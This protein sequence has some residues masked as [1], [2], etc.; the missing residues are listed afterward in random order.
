MPPRS[1]ARRRSCTAAANVRAW[2]RSFTALNHFGARYRYRMELYARVC[3]LLLASLLFWLCCHALA[4]AAKNDGEEEDDDDGSSSSSSNGMNPIILDVRF[5]ICLPAIC[6]ML[7]IVNDF[8]IRCQLGGTTV[9]Y[10]S[11]QLE[12]CYDRLENFCLRTK[13]AENGQ[14]PSKAVA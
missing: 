4:L 13:S 2:T 3:A 14:K 7:L 6:D 5:F 1:P 12:L 9:E 11:A 10:A 8:N